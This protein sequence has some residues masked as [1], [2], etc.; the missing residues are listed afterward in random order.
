MMKIKR[1]QNIVFLGLMFVG[2]FCLCYTIIS[3]LDHYLAITEI[4][5]IK[6]PDESNP[7]ILFHYF[8]MWKLIWLL[9]TTY[10]ISF[11]TVYVISYL[12]II[13]YNKWQRTK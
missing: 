9:A 5:G 7:G 13:G 12:L 8:N 11:G 2:A 4:L 10:I 6:G 3:Q 1:L